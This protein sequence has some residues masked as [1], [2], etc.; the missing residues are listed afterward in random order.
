MTSLLAATYQRLEISGQS[1][2][3][4]VSC[5]CRLRFFQFILVTGFGHVIV[6]SVM[7]LRSS[8][9]WWRHNYVINFQTFQL[10]W[11]PSDQ[12]TE[13]QIFLL[14]RRI[15]SQLGRFCARTCCNKRR[16][17]K[18]RDVQTLLKLNRV[19]FVPIFMVFILPFVLINFKFLWNYQNSSTQVFDQTWTWGMCKVCFYWRFRVKICQVRNLRNHR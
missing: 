10:R 2:S 14:G 8:C 16:P 9:D 3:L 1:Q 4:K 7:W 11:I 6:T 12:M 15:L 13:W 18:S 5:N 19:Y 17:R